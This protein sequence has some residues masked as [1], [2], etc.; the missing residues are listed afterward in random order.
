MPNLRRPAKGAHLLKSE[1]D[2]V[3]DVAKRLSTGRPRA[4]SNPQK[5]TIGE[6]LFFDCGLLTVEWKQAGL[7]SELLWP[8]EIL[9][10]MER[11]EAKSM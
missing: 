2:E 11:R 8:M 1:L 3:D 10:I 4:A 6:S 9:I 7:S 5:V